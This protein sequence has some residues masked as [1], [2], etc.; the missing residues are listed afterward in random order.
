MITPTS[1]ISIDPICVFSGN[2]VKSLAEFQSGCR[3]VTR[4]MGRVNDLGISSLDSI[5]L[6]KLAITGV[7]L[8]GN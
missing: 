3:E 8:I 1:Q 6:E 5:D 7:E 2:S 4:L